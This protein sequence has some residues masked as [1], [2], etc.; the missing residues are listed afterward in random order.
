M[1]QE[2]IKRQKYLHSTCYSISRC[3]ILYHI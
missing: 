2:N 3:A 1:L